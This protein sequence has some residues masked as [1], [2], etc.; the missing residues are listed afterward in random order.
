MPDDLLATTVPSV[1]DRSAPDVAALLRTLKGRTPARIF[2]GRSGAS[3][4]TETQLRLREDHAA[5]RDAVWRELDVARDLAQVLDTHGLFEV[6]TQAESKLEFLKFPARGRFLRPSARS[7]IL[8]RCPRSAD[9]QVVIGDGL[10]AT[11]VA[12]QV[13]ELLPRL[14]DGAQRFAWTFG[15]PFVVRYCRV[16]ILNDIG[17]LLDP[18]VVVLLI[19]ERP[20]LASAESLSAYLAYRPR[21]GHTDAQRNLVSNI[22]ASGVSVQ[23]AAERI[24]QLARLC[25]DVQQSGVSVKEEFASNLFRLGTP[26]PTLDRGPGAPSSD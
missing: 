4:R 2:E 25:R 20:G 11:A 17:D 15:Q 13:P 24:L 1:P 10:S 5:A 26:Q 8:T 23:S 21:S 7:E 3:Y 12:S 6:G 9:L 14:A 16:G 18:A 22:H 19:G